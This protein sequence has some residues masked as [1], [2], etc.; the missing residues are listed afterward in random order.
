MSTRA[1][2]K[3][4]P[5]P[6]APAK[7]ESKR[8]FARILTDGL[9]FDGQE[10]AALVGMGAGSPARVELGA[11]APWQSADHDGWREGS[12]WVQGPDA[13]LIDALSRPLFAASASA[14]AGIT[15]GSRSGQ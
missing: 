11:P 8:A 15:A 3:R 2:E 13:V 4:A 6:P 12:I 5:R 1:T 7:T 9:R 14:V 10:R